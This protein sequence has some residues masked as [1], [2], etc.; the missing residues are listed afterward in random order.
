MQY[1]PCVYTML[2]NEYYPVTLIVSNPYNIILGDVKINFTVPQQYRNKGKSIN[3][4]HELE[5]F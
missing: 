3:N 2:V 4:L 1:L 5:D